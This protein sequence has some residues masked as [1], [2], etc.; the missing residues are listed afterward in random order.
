MKIDGTVALGEIQKLHTEEYDYAFF[1]FE[2]VLSRKRNF[3]D[4]K[5]GFINAIEGM[6]EKG[7]TTIPQ[8]S[9]YQKQL[10]CKHSIYYLMLLERM[11][12]GKES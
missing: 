6:E 8:E 5:L 11:N 12:K 10:Y 3:W 7:I 4:A 1:D 2:S 9:L